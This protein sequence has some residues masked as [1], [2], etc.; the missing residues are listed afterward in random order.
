MSTKRLAAVL[1]ASVA[2]VF[3]LLASGAA[4]GEPSVA[5]AGDPPLLGDFSLESVGGDLPARVNRLDAELPK[6][7]V[8]NI[9]A[10]ANRKATP[11]CKPAHPT[12]PE[13][14]IRSY[15]FNPGDTGTED[16]Y[17]QGVST[18]ADAQADQLWGTKHAL[19]V[20]WY[21]HADDGI[22]KG[23]RVSFLDPDTNTYQHVLLVYPFDGTNGPSYESVTTPQAGDGPSV[24]AGGL[25]WYGNYLYV[26]DTRRGI[27]VFDMRK[28]MDL[29][30]AGD[31]GDITDQDQVGLH[32]GKY[33]G[34]G[35]RYVMPEVGIWENPDGLAEFP[36][37]NR[38]NVS[39]ESKFSYLSLDRSEAPDLLVSGEYC[40]GATDA[41]HYGRVAQWPMDSDTGRPQTGPGG[42]WYAS[43]AYRL[44]K[45]NVQGATSTD[46]RWYLSSTGGGEGAHGHLQAAKANKT[47]AG[48]L[49]TDGNERNVAGGVEDLSYWPGRNELWTV[50]EYPDD[51][52]CTP[53]HVTPPRSTTHRVVPRWRR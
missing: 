7:G 9:L 15:C 27:R 37:G 17:P 14:P 31:K 43:N 24:H 1:G 3:P 38:C 4:I 33:Y 23:V 12:M 47:G 41:N 42:Y 36:S 11:G 51:R 44:P 22:E 35:Y 16:W 26:P 30:S 18:V 13:P 40:A 8:Q 25:V 21:D 52:V 28:I 50:T 2:L 10:Q 46:G 39:G 20:S 49:T 32:G 53:S 19:L 48:V 34:F 5:A 6:L 29:K 45:S